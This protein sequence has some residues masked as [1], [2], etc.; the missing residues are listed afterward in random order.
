MHVCMRIIIMVNQ[1]KD[2]LKITISNSQ[3]VLVFVCIFQAVYL[4]GVTLGERI[5]VNRLW[6]A[7]RQFFFKKG[8]A[9]ILQKVFGSCIITIAQ[10]PLKS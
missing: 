2:A 5:T 1:I 8:I 7:T 3:N 9:L 6:L 4:K 10:L